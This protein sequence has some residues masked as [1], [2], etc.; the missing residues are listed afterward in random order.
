[1]LQ[2]MPQRTQKELDA[3]IGAREDKED[4]EK[5]EA[6]FSVKHQATGELRGED[7]QCRS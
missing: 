4:E 7:G 6:A 2:R 3:T 1:M 5:E